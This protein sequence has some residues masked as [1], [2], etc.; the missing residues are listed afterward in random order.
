MRTAAREGHIARILQ[1]IALLLLLALTRGT[2]A[3]RLPIKSYTSADGLPRDSINR[4]VQDSHGYLWFCTSEGLSRFDGYRFVNYGKEQGLPSRSVN[5]F[6]ETRSGDYWLATDN[7]VCRFVPDP[8]PRANGDD[9][10]E[11]PQRFVVYN[12]GHTQQ[13]QYI[14][15]LCEDQTGAIWCGTNAGL[16]R[17][18]RI[19]GQ[20][21]QG[22]LSFV[23]IRASG[24][25][26]WD[27]VKAIIEDQRGNLWISMSVELFKRRPDGVIETYLKTDSGLTAALLE[28]RNGQIYVGTGAGLYQLTLG[29]KPDGSKVVRAYTTKDGLASNVITLAF[30]ASDGALWIGTSGGLNKFLPA[31]SGGRFESYTAVNGLSDAWVTSMTEDSEGNLWMGTSASGVMKLVVNGFTTY[32]EADGLAGTRIVS[33]IKDQAG[34]LCV[35]GDHEVGLQRFIGSFDGR[36]LKDVRLVLPKGVP[37]WGWGWYQGIFQDSRGEWWMP[38]SQGLARYPRSRQLEELARTRPKAIYAKRDGLLGDLIFRL[39]EDSRGDIWISTINQGDGMTRWER[40]TET[41]HRYSPADGIPGSAPTAFCE[42][43][44]GDLWIGFY[45]GG[46]ARYRAGR[47]TFFSNGDGVPPG[48]VRGLYFDSVGRLWV[49]T[50]E[51]GALR[52]DDPAAD[53]PRFTTYT[54]ADGLLTNEA[55]CVTE[56]QW[57][58]IYIGTGRGINRLD[59]ATGRMRAFTTADGLAN[60]FINVACRDREG[61]LW[62]GTLKGL[63][64][65]IPEPDRP[66]LPPPIRVSALR[67]SGD[68]QPLSEL[69]ATEV[70]VRDLDANRNHIQIDFFS[71]SFGLGESLRYQYKLEGSSADWGEPGSER[72]VNY[73]NLAPG[74]YRFLVRAVNSIGATSD[75]PAAVAFRILPPIY[76]RWWFIAIA[77]FVITSGALAFARYRYQRLR[78]VQEAQEALRRS[79]E[80]RLTELERVRTRIATDL[81]DDIGSSLTQIAILSEVAHQR[82]DSGDPERGMQPLSRI[83]SVSNELVDTMSDIVWAINPKKDHL[84]D[85]LQRMRRFASDIFTARGIALRFNA[86]D[87]ASD[88]ELGANVRREVFLIFKESVNNVVKHSGCTRAEVAFRVE[89]DWL[90]LTVSDNGKGF[91]T[92]LAGGGDVQSV[93]S[94]KGGNGLFSMRKRAQE[95]NGRFEIISREGEGTTATLR[96]PATQQQSEKK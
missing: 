74:S 96:V 39:F 56:D 54:T 21:S 41:F 11:A 65:L 78:A 57:G 95:M 36:K 77:A 15:A 38:T 30:Q 1:S 73:A 47:F 49:A 46:V 85:L 42:G 53:R 81:H 79:R 92:K 67:I 37:Q 28:D 90:T 32:L 82:V 10:F 50:S 55:T 86:P 62:F 25:I 44:S 80:E 45:H 71:I 5:D 34:E 3:Q 33:M 66:S 76:K 70:T 18:D 16:Y 58:M 64:R 87:G 20:G 22:S 51:G 63:S 72:S 93:S 6:L 2:Q 35:I 26:V 61:A 12:P 4:I 83:I 75:K 48:M 14:S 89:V 69:G 8:A 27:P 68:S 7:G 60:S 88:I 40:A 9:A 13:Q 43:A 19:N 91:D 29:S 17:L 23:A 31:K 59:P 84:S 94:A 52:I 24:D